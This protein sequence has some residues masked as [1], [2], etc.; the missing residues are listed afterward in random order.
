MEECMICLDEKEMFIF[1]PCNHKVCND[2]F[3]SL[4]S[5]TNKCPLCSKIIEPFNET[6]TEFEIQ[7]IDQPTNNR[8][9]YI[10]RAAIIKLFFVVFISLSIITYMFILI[11]KYN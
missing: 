1:F 4:V 3:P 8:P 7:I 6:E 2:C 10:S 11:F 9:L 5:Y